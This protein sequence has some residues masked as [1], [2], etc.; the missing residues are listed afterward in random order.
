MPATTC[1][2]MG[3]IFRHPFCFLIPDLHLV[4]AEIQDI[5]FFFMSNKVMLMDDVSEQKNPT[6]SNA[7]ERQGNQW[8]LPLNSL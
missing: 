3:L 4:A 2:P 7:E 8:F 6:T 5:R 1:Q